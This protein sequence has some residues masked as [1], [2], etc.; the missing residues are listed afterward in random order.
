MPSRSVS[1]WIWC[2]AALMVAGSVAIGSMRL[3]AA[4]EAPASQNEL[5]EDVPRLQEK[6]D[7]PTQPAIPKEQFKFGGK[8]FQQWQATL[9]SDLK[10]QVREEA[11]Q[12]LSTFGKNG[13]ADAATRAILEIAATYDPT[14]DD[15]SDR[16]VLHSASLEIGRLGPL[17]IP[18]LQDELQRGKTNGRRFAALVLKQMFARAKPA[19]AALIRALKDEDA[20]VRIQTAICL[21]HFSTEKGPSFVK[22]LVEAVAA[23]FY[24]RQGQDEKETRKVLETL[25]KIGKPAQAAVPALAELLKKPDPRWQLRFAIANAILEIG[26]DAKMMQP[27][28]PSLLAVPIEARMGSPRDHPGLSTRK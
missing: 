8:S 22:A 5:V 15:N 14:T 24:P 20:F 27:I 3:W 28:Y 10:P 1:R 7:Q 25:A 11:F 2:A 12:A 19:E 13:Y 21:A 26:G 6:V 23:S 18:A 9:R 4:T 17:A 16:E